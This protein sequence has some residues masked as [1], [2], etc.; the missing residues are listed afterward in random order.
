MDIIEKSLEI[1]LKAYSGQKDKAG[2]TYI[3]HPLRLMA[4]MDTDEE[5]AVALLHD[6]IEDSD[7]TADDLLTQGIP[8]NIVNA[9]QCLSKIKGESYD[10]FIKRVK[11]NSL[12]TK[13]KIAD[14]ED[15]I[16]ILRLDTVNEND[17]SRVAKYHRAWKSLH[18]TLGGNR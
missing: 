3:L 16:N 14:I 10:L 6:V 1:A 9:V 17:L 11:T 5:R 4:K 2:Q 18:S 12:A 15:N 8:S 13:I 7:Y